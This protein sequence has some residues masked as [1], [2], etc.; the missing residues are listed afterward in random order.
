MT[1]DSGNPN[2]PIWPLAIWLAVAFAIPLAF[3]YRVEDKRER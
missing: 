2:Y 1:F 3:A